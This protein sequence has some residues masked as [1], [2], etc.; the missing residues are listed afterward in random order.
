MR[1]A[2]AAFSHNDTGGSAPYL[3]LQSEVTTHRGPM[4]KHYTPRRLTVQ[5]FTSFKRVFPLLNVGLT[6]I[7]HHMIASSVSA[8][9][10]SRTR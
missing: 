9:V 6:E 10:S 8:L 5:I 4:Q 3:W 1:C 7:P 2:H